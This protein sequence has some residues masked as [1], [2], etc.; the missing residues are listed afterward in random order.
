MPPRAKILIVDDEPAITGA[1][2][3]ILGDQGYKVFTVA[4]VARA[5]ALLHE[6]RFD[7]VFT[8]LRLPD[9]S[10]MDLLAQVKADSPATAVVLMT[11]HGSLDVTIEAIKKGAYYYLDK[12]FTPDQVM[13]LVER[14][15][16]FVAIH[17]ENRHLKRIISGDH[18]AF[19]IIGRNEAMRRIYETIRMTA[20]SDASVLIEGESGTGKELIAAAFHLR[21]ERASRPFMRI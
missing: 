21:S 10:G 5:V 1:L 8:D 11:A 9:A 6:Q 19:G 17:E 4:T 13:V 7:L 2:A 20:A 3:M 18:Q 16:Q 12:P 15:L 14:A